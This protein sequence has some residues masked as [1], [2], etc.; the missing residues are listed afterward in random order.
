MG[1][2]CIK[3]N[4]ECDGCLACKSEIHYYCP[5]CGE[6]VYD[7]VFITGSGDIVGCENCIE[8]KEPY[9]VFDDEIN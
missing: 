5:I 6:E 7:T 4:T 2:M 8:L 3:G 9:E 1:F